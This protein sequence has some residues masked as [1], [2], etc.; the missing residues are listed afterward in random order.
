MGFLGRLAAAGLAL[1]GLAALGTGVATADCDCTSLPT[2]DDCPKR[3]IDYYLELSPECRPITSSL[4]DVTTAAVVWERTIW[5]QE[6]FES[7]DETSQG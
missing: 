1:L 5:T 2:A 3:C 6:L 4:I 7:R